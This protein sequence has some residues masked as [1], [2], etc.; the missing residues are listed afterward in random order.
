MATSLGPTNHIANACFVRK[1]LQISTEAVYGE[2]LHINF[3]EQ[4]DDCDDVLSVTLDDDA[5]RMLIKACCE[6]IAR[7][8]KGDRREDDHGI[9]VL[10]R[11]RMPRVS[12]EEAVA[13]LTVEEVSQLRDH[14]C[15]MGDLGNMPV[16]QLQELL[17]R[18][19][20]PGTLSDHAAARQR[21]LN[22]CNK[23]VAN[24]YPG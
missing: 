9:D 8:P 10:D 16:F 5:C 20:H 21:F 17:Y 18:W 13:R 6:Y 22:D 24:V 23:G 7:T 2:G 1:Y 14:L 11:S 12:F 3:A 4:N 19:P 15:F